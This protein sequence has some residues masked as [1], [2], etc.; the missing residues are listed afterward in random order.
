MY[1]NALRAIVTV[2]GYAFYP[3]EIMKTRVALKRCD[4][5]RTDGPLVRI[6]AECAHTPLE[7]INL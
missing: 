3:P 5:T 1:F 4:Q 6:L 2:E 7:I